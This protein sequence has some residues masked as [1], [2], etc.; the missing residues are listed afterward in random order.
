MKHLNLSSEWMKK[1]IWS[2]KQ[3]FKFC[4]QFNT[5]PSSPVVTLDWHLSA[6]L[7]NPVQTCRHLSKEY[8]TWETCFVGGKSNIVLHLAMFQEFLKR[9][10]YQ[11]W[12][13][14]FTRVHT[15]FPRFFK[16]LGVGHYS[17][18]GHYTRQYGIWK[19]FP[20][21]SKLTQKINIYAHVYPEKC[22]I[23]SFTK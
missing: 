12:G 18:V 2:V 14:D 20:K 21:L 9:I 5:Y 16:S 23:H 10:R 17:K 3:T 19:E 15:N 22:T 6:V 4:K 13:W 11:N 1:A 8:W 7:H